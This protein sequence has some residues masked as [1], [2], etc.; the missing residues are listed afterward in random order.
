LASRFP[1]CPADGT[2]ESKEAICS[3]MDSGEKM[4]PKV[5][6]TKIVISDEGERVV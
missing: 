6:M 4:V 2:I 5:D 3:T 1:F